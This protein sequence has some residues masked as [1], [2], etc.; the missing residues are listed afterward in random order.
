MA[1]KRLYVTNADRQKAYRERLAAG[2]RVPSPPPSLG[3]RQPRPPSRPA[4]LARLSV[5]LQALAGEYED[6]LE[7][8]PES[9][10]ETDQA[11]RLSETVEQLAAA[12]ELLADVDPPR[13]FGRD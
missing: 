8:L 4:R 6:W 5:E 11:A 7:A 13:G 3:K 9:L 12:A 2:R 10:K 1:R